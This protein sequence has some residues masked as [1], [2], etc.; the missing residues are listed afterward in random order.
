[1]ANS[2]KMSP[3]LARVSLLVVATTSQSLSGVPPTPTLDYEYQND[4]INRLALPRHQSVTPAEP[5]G[6][7]L[8][9]LN[10]TEE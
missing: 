10:E 8:E 6:V 5:V 7:R 3:A 4:F 1:M 9:G 2:S